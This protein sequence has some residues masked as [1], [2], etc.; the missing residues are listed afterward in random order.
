MNPLVSILIPAFNS[1][2]W[3]AETIRSAVGQN[4]HRKEVILVDDG[5]TDRTLC[6]AKQFAS[7]SVCVISQANQGASAARNRALAL[8]QGDYVQW[9]D[10]DDL[11]APDKIKLQIEAAEMIRDSRVLLSSAWGRFY[12]RHQ[13]ARFSA[14]A[15]WGDMTPFEW[16]LR[17]VGESAWMAIESW[18]VSR[19]LTQLAG[20]WDESMSRDDD[21]EYFCRVVSASRRIKFVPDA[22]SYCRGGN[23]GS[24][25]SDSSLSRSKLESQF[26]S[27]C[28]HI[29][30]LRSFEDSERT[31]AA[32][33]QFLRAWLIDFYPEQT[34]LVAKLDT[35]ALELG[36]ELGVPKLKWKYALT[37]S[38]CGWKTAKRAMRS[39]PV[40]GILIRRSWDKMLS[41]CCS[42]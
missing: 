26:K 30:C 12:F 20:P 23:L 6:I 39:L 27:I 8:A 28:R 21:G 4:W 13:K 35:L 38:V 17:K 25:S 10:A 24:L 2:G 41:I 11:L 37:R 33:L 18:L 3:I 32:C 42:K 36:G 40:P 7:K 16:L 34:D 1:E 29:Q 22:K 14:G 19:E 15:L 31:K 9:L 5:S